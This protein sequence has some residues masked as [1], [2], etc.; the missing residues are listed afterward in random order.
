MQIFS[1]KSARRNSEPDYANLGLSGQ[2]QAVATDHPV[3]RAEQVSDVRFA[4]QLTLVTS[5][6][7]E[8][9]GGRAVG[10]HDARQRAL[11]HYVI[12]G[13]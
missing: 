9:G 10:R 4:R 2:T 6:S 1:R 13:R 12:V 3:T 5:E 7:V 11:R 8:S